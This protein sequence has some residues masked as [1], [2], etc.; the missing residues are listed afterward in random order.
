MPLNVQL[1]GTKMGIPQTPPFGHTRTAGAF[2]MVPSDALPRL[3]SRHEGIIRRGGAIKSGSHSGRGEGRGEPPKRH[4]CIYMDVG[5]WTGGQRG[6]SP[7][8]KVKEIKG[9]NLTS[10]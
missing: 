2:G 4:V 10:G 9:D 5:M 7:P 6:A 1:T 8:P 3:K